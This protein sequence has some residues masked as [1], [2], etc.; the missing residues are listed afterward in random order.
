METKEQIVAA[1][2]NQVCFRPW[3][4]GR[5]ALFFELGKLSPKPRDRNSQRGTFTI[6]V[7]ACPWQIFKDEQLFFNDQS[8]FKQMDERIGEFEGKTLIDIKFHPELHEEEI[9]FTGGFVIH[10]YH[11]HPEDEWYILTP[12]VEFVVLKDTTEIVPAE[13]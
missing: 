11:N 5:D 4:G 3:R 7:T 9:V 2:K 8:D 10:T 6:G 1:I 13:E 12:S